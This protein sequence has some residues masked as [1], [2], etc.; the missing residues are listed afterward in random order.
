MLSHTDL[1]FL[2]SHRTG[3]NG[4]HSSES[5]NSFSLCGRH[6]VDQST[7]RLTV[8]RC[9]I[10]RFITLAT[11]RIV[12]GKSCIAVPLLS[13]GPTKCGALYFSRQV[14]VPDPADILPLHEAGYQDLCRN[15]H[16]TVR[17]PASLLQSAPG[18]YPCNIRQ[19][20]LPLPLSLW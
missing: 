10:R 8:F 4:I 18:S 2:R 6:K 7:S 20:L 12:N 13:I 17:I 9:R 15:P 19:K 16:T 3:Y 14:Q 5:S 11:S 1:A